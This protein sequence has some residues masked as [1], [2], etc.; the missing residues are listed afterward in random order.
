MADCI[1]NQ[2]TLHDL[3]DYNC[4]RQVEARIQALLATVDEEAP[5]EFLTCDVS[6]EI[7]CLKLGK[8]LQY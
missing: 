2:F 7:Q 3:C 6:K 5:V 1:E 8:A 4:K